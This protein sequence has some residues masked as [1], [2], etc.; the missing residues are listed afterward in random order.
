M[1][2]AGSQCNWNKVIH[3]FGITVV[4]DVLVD[5]FVD[6]GRESVGS[7]L[8]CYRLAAQEM[9]VPRWKLRGFVSESI[10]GSPFV[11]ILDA[12][13]SLEFRWQFCCDWPAY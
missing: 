6:P 13:E 9:L 10:Q 12:T 2:T 8:F 5:V 11:A 7:I 4:N 1:S 3:C